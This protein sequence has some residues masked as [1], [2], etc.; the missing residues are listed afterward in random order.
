MQESFEPDV[1]VVEPVQDELEVLKARADRLGISYHPSIKV[2][3]LREKLEKEMSGEVPEKAAPTKVVKEEETEA[4]RNN[5]KRLEANELIRIRVTCMNPQKKDWDGE[6][7]TTGNAIV[8]TIKKYV[9][10]NADEGWHVPRMIYQQ[11]LERQCQ[12]FYT[13]TNR[14]GVKTRAGKLIR[15]FNIEVLPPLTVEELKEIAQRQ[16][17]AA[18][19]AA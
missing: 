5:R 11:M 10:F 19:S 1:D 15:E 4:Q 8:G 14:N 17:M 13:V 16:A 18:G 6:I 3:K 2:E 7:F 9:P 12:V